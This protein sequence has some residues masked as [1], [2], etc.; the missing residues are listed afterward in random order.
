MKRHPDVRSSALSQIEVEIAD[1]WPDSL[2]LSYVLI[3]DVTAI[4]FP[5]IVAPVRQD[6]LWRHTCFEAF[7]WKSS[8]TEYYELN[9]SPSTQWAAYHF[10]SYR[11]GM[12]EVAEIN[13][14]R[15]QTDARSSS[16]ELQA[17]VE[18]NRLLSLEGSNI[19]RLGL[20]AVIEEKSGRKS[21]WALEH[22]PGKPDF[23]HSDGFL[24]E[25]SPHVKK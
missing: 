5:A 17:S 11:S 9:F 21:F 19:W 18:P 10:S 20:S 8:G 3:G 24:H 22:P 1:L 13:A 14:V 16:F 7:L 25:L 6:E 15:I 23:H 4:E 2:D 12:R